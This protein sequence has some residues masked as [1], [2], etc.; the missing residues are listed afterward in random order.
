MTINGQTRRACTT[1][2]ADG[3]VLEPLY[4]YPVIKDLVVDFGTKT[5]ADEGKYYTVRTGSF[6][7][8]S[9]Y[10]WPRL[11]TGPWF[12]MDVEEEKC[13]SCAEKPCVRACPINL[14]ENLEDREGLRLPLYSAPIRIEDGRARLT[15][16]CNICA[17]WS[18]A[19]KCPTQAFQVVAGG[20]G[21]RINPKKCIGC[22]LCV[23]AC[24]LGN[25]W[26]NLERGHAV[27]CDL[28]E[29]NPECVRACPYD[30]IRFEIIRK[31]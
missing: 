2:V 3:M 23:A 30:A 4:D 10:R 8:Q 19:R 20:I 9:R 13:I 24:T 14:I 28:C 29:G 16:V 15:G 1:R 25:I 6:A 11:L 31:K 7:L 12:F 22:G 26:L 21:A 18:C 5:K 27:K 17:S